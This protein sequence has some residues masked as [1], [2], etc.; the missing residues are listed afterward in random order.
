[1]K[2]YSCNGLR[3]TVNALDA[4][5]EFCIYEINE[6]TKEFVYSGDFINYELDSELSLLNDTLNSMLFG[7]IDEYYKELRM[8]PIWVT[9]VGQNSEMSISVD[10]FNE[11]IENNKNTSFYKHLYLTDCKYLVGTMQNLLFAVEEAFIRY[12]R[13]ISISYDD[14]KYSKEEGFTGTVCEM[15]SNSILA[16]SAVETYFTKAYS[17]LDIICK[18]CYELQFKNDDYS[19][20]RKLLSS[21]KLWGD[22]KKLKL[23]EV[24]NTLFEKC[25]SICTIESIRNEIIHNGTWEL[26]PKIFTRYKSGQ[27]KERYLLFPDIVQGHL[28]TFKNR[29]HFFSNRRKIN[30]ILPEIHEEFKKRLLNTIKI[31]NKGFFT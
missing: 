2:K 16:S 28:A 25:T 24:P 21:S 11:M 17:I 19:R 7:D 3:Y 29:R 1:M 10:E 8:L 27:A 13:T 31:V 14:E 23:Y 4:D 22:R 5:S 12:Y 9:E 30:D 15:S 26:Y 20:Y 18:I 6:K